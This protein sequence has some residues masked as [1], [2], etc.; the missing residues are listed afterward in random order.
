MIV[1][2]SLGRRHS[3]L[4]FGIFLTP[5]MLGIIVKKIIKFALED[6]FLR[7][8]YIYG[9]VCCFISLFIFFFL[10]LGYTQLCSMLTPYSV[11]RDHF[12]KTGLED[13]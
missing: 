6:T 10:L 7:F 5:E 12:R 11:L 3:H 13:L 4:L 8:I 2:V 9:G 1:S